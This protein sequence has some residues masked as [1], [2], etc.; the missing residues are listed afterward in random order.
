MRRA[1][2]LDRSRPLWEMYLVQCLEGGRVALYAKI[3]HALIGGVQ[4]ALGLEPQTPGLRPEDRI[5]GPGRRTA[6]GAR[7]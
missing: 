1:S 4:P 2:P 3:H 7:P 5:S 6:S